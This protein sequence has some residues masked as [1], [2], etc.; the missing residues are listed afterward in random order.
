QRHTT[1]KKE[2]PGF[3]CLHTGPGQLAGENVAQQRQRHCKFVAT[4]IR[5][6]VAQVRGFSIGVL[7]R[8]NDTVARMIYDLRQLRVEAS[9]EGGNALTDS[10]AVEVLLSLFTLADHPGHS[11]AWFHLQNS[12]LQDDLRMFPD[13]D[14]LA[15]HLRRELLTQGYGQFMHGWAKRLA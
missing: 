12:P 3:V 5:D 8:K 2:A 6:L 11:I 1:A 4:A 13:A 10:P 14:S 15:Q 7:C 9:E